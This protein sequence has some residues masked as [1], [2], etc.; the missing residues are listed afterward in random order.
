MV[1]EGDSNF[2]VPVG[3]LQHPAE[4]VGSQLLP[5]TTTPPVSGAYLS[6]TSHAISKA[7]ARRHLLDQLKGQ[8]S[9]QPCHGQLPSP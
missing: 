6:A 1:S 7:L 9:N 2:R 8:R 5:I 3:V 4:I